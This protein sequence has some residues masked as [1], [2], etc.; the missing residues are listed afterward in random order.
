MEEISVIIPTYNRSKTIGR[1][2]ESVLN[3]TYP[4]AEVVVVDDNSTDNTG[5]VLAALCN[6]KVR[7]YK[8]DKNIGAGGARNYGVEMSKSE[9][10]AFQ[11]SDDEWF[12]DKLEK[13]ISYMNQYP[14]CGMIYSAYEMEV[15]PGY[16]HRVPE[17]DGSL[18]LEG[19]IFSN[20]LLRNTCGAPTML[21]KRSA[22][23]ELGGFDD[24]MRSL[25]D[26]DLVIRIAKNYK[27]GFVP[28][29]LVRVPKTPGSIST[30]KGNFYE[31]RCYMLQKYRSDYLETGMFDE[32]VHEILK[33]AE[34]D[35]VL[36]QVKKM[37]LL[38]IMR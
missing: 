36:E 38:Y 12:L 14:D 31:N 2:V 16:Y 10:I 19:D 30:M 7:Y 25:E 34:R 9:W 3:Q 29:V 18:R 21:M 17:M 11:D 28:E 37:L 26:W 1:A 5:E 32:T 8:M 20:V 22:F 27:I 15:Y 23:Q 24:T 4:V 6:K 33:M 35:N 13:Q